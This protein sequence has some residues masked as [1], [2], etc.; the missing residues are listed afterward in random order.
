MPF[1]L[2]SPIVNAFAIVDPSHHLPVLFSFVALIS[3][4]HYLPLPNAAALIISTI[5]F[6]FHYFCLAMPLL[7][8]PCHYHYLLSFAFDPYRPPECSLFSLYF[9]G[10]WFLK[11]TS[12]QSVTFIK[13]SAKSKNVRSQR[14]FDLR[15]R[16][17]VYQHLTPPRPCMGLRLRL[18]YSS[19]IKS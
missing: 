10:P 3:P 8:C 11:R 14:T 2:C 17:V 6:C 16:R 7:F 1:P 15:D 13:L 9:I 5:I 18:L 4:C 12:A 19:Y